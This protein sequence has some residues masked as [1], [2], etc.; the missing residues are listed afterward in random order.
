M[1]S[2]CTRMMRG[3]KELVMHNKAPLWN[4]SS[5]VYQ[6]D[7][8]GRV[9]QE[10]AKNFQIEYLGQQV[11]HICTVLYVYFSFGSASGFLFDTDADPDPDPTFYPDE[12]PDPV[13]SFQIEAQT[14]E[15]LLIFHTN[16]LVIGKL[17]RIRIRFRIQLITLMKIRMRIWILIFI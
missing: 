6:L 16:S 15:K 3:W 7:F 1:V 11:R 10:S 2:L 13:P 4:E 14:L 8:G 12:D 5:Q 9:T 17:M